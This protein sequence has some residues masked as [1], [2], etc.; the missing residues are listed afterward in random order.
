M[1]MYDFNRLAVFHFCREV[2]IKSGLAILYFARSSHPIPFFVISSICCPAKSGMDGVI[3][4]NVDEV[5]IEP[6]VSLSG[7]SFSMSLYKGRDRM[8]GLVIIVL[9]LSRN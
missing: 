1:A 8:V 7:Q 5:E 9:H 6:C 3:R 2:E 4:R